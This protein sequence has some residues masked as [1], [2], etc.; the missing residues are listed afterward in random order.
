MDLLAAGRYGMYGYQRSSLT[1]FHDEIE[2]K[3]DLA[4]ERLRH[5]V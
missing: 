2:E 5:P 3:Y 4:A 1:P